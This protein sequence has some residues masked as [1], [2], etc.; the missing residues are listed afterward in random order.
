MNKSNGNVLA[1]R[2]ATELATMVTDQQGEPHDVLLK[3]HARI[4]D[5]LKEFQLRMALLMDKLVQARERGHA[6]GSVSR[7]HVVRRKRKPIGYKAKKR[8]KRKIS[9]A[10]RRKNRRN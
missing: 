8:K 7:H 4:P 10:S 1:E 9:N 6:I 3:G 5:S 2:S